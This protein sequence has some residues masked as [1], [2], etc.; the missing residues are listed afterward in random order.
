MCYV[1]VAYVHLCCWV[2]TKETGSLVL[3]P[4]LVWCTNTHSM[5]YSLVKAQ[6]ESRSGRRAEWQS[7]GEARWAE[8]CLPVSWHWLI[9][10]SVRSLS[11]SNTCRQLSQLCSAGSS[12]SSSP[13][14][15]SSG[16]SSLFFRCPASPSSAAL[17]R[18]HSGSAKP[19]EMTAPHSQRGDPQSEVLQ[20]PLLDNKMDF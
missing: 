10:C 20:L 11:D 16:D 13:S 17:L 2:P 1:C 8:R 14:S 7:G 12:S 3:R 15:P 5:A 4:P 19:Q 6:S 9:L 18:A